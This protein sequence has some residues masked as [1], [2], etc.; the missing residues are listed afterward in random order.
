MTHIIHKGLEFFLRPKKVSLN[1]NLKIGSAKMSPEDV[2]KLVEKVPVFMMS[3]Y[4]DKAFM[5]RELEISSADFPNGTIFFSYYEPLPAELNWDLD[6]KLIVGLSKYYHFYDLISSMNELIDEAGSLS[7]SLGIYEEWLN[8]VLVK[9]PEE[10]TETL[11]GMLS[12]F[13]LVYT[14]KIFGRMFK[15]NAEELKRRAHELAY[16]F[17]EISSVGSD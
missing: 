4:D 6:K 15:G 10:D 5:E 9:I 3:Y 13:S 11:R 2:Q 17:Y 7:F 14:T 16:K 12:R 8:R 1:L